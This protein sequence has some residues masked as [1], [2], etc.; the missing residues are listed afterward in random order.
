[1][2]KRTVSD[3]KSRTF[4]WNC[5]AYRAHVAASDVCSLRCQRPNVHPRL[6]SRLYRQARMQDTVVAATIIEQILPEYSI[7]T[8]RLEYNP[9]TILDI[10]VYKVTPASLL[11]RQPQIR[12]MSAT[13]GTVRLQ[14]DKERTMSISTS[15]FSTNFVKPIVMVTEFAF[16]VIANNFHLLERSRD[17]WALKRQSSILNVAHDGI[18]FWNCRQ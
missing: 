18:A 11:F 5:R 16:F 13:S 10:A 17:R 12:K 8:N 15:A 9:C 2:S 7:T 4:C 14:I 6:N 3:R 1:M